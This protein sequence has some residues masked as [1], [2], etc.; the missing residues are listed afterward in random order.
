MGL[1]QCD[2]LETG[3]AY[4]SWG[5]TIVCVDLYSPETMLEVKSALY[6][7][8]NIRT[9][10]HTALW[11]PEDETALRSWALDEPVANTD[12]MREGPLGWM[13]PS[14]EGIETMVRHLEW[15]GLSDRVPLLAGAVAEAASHWLASIETTDPE[16]GQAG[17]PEPPSAEQPA[18]PEDEPRAEGPTDIIPSLPTPPPSTAAAA[19]SYRN[20]GVAVAAVGICA[21]VAYYMRG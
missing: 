3:D 8:S 20:I 18:P 21:A 7:L 19:P 6:G 11:T 1:T 16:I 13:V 9:S 17:Q 10:V 2:Y 14:G 5:R 15:Q 12:V 4:S